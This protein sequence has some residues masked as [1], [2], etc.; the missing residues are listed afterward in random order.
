[1]PAP[2]HFFQGLAGTQASGT[3]QGLLAGRGTGCGC[4][5]FPAGALVS[6]SARR[7]LSHDSST[8]SGAT[9]AP[10]LWMT[11]SARVVSC[12]GLQPS[13]PAEEAVQTGLRGLLV[14]S[15]HPHHRV[16]PSGIAGAGQRPH[17]LQRLHP[18]LAE[19]PGFERLRRFLEVRERQEGLHDDRGLPGHA[20]PGNEIPRPFGPVNYRTG[21]VP[22]P[23]NGGQPRWLRWEGLAP[24]GRRPSGRCARVDSPMLGPAGGRNGD[25]CSPDR[26][27]RPG[28]Y[29]S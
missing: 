25:R 10:I 26:R 15:P 18:P 8:A 1:M 2:R 23:A 21:G 6:G 11:N 22:A 9:R 29:Q 3:G 12:S 13:R 19:P 27:S 17:D 20:V 16:V 7:S 28:P 14:S 24:A 4:G 5:S